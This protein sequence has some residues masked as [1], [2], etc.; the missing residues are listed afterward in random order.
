LERWFAT[1]LLF[2]SG[3]AEVT[4][5]RPLCEERVVLFRAETESNATALA[6]EYGRNEAHEYENVRGEL[7]AWRFVGV[8]KVEAVS[9]P[10]NLGWEV[11]SR[12][13]RRSLRTLRSL[14][15]KRRQ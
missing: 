10:E 1:T 15:S 4:S 13:T 2:K 7:V 9:P 5:V 3:I 6:A 14:S 8:E 12:F 11:A